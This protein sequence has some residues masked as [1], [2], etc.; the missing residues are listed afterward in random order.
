MYN[1]IC[2]QKGGGDIY[3]F[4]EKQILVSAG[5][6]FLKWNDFLSY[7]WINVGNINSEI[8]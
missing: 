8:W 1:T 6:S 4:V 2:H 3:I 5:V 7:L